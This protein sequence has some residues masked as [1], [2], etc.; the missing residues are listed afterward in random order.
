MDAQPYGGKK[1]GADGGIDGIIYFKPDGK[2][3]QRCVVS[4]K[5]GGN[6]GVAMVK[7]LGATMEKEK[8]AMGV[9]L[10]LAMPTKPM[11]EYAA[12]VGVLHAANGKSYPRL[13]IV[14]LAELFQG[15]RP[16]IPYVDAAAVFKKAGKDAPEQ[17]GLDL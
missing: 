9:F 17:E 1:K 4:V 13:Q 8:A 16:Q 11:M 3:T 2:T 15:K 12:S 7:D 10:T 6:V 14:T 5:G